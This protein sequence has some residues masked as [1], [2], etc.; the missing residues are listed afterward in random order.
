MD[1]IF[2]PNAPKP[3]EWLP[4]SGRHPGD[5]ASV[6]SRA[7][8]SVSASRMPAAV[9]KRQRM[10]RMRPVMLRAHGTLTRVL[11]FLAQTD[12]LI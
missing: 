10:W 4:I 1:P 6:S 7:Q 2:A 12:W 5:A 8:I 9:W 11:G 3:F